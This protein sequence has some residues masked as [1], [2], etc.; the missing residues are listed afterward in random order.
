MASKDSQTS[1]AAELTAGSDSAAPEHTEE[2]QLAEPVNQE[3]GLATEIDL[4]FIKPMTYLNFKTSTRGKHQV[5]HHSNRQELTTIQT[6][7]TEV[8]P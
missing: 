3:A 4:N 6:S 2:P 8:M 7:S 1:V 5:L